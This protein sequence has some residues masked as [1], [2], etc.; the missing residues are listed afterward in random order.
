MGA[1]F[2]LS[3]APL[4]AQDS[5]QMY[6]IG[7][8]RT[9]VPPVIDGRL[10]EPVWQTAAVIDQFTQQEP[11]EGAPVSERTEVRILYD[12]NYLYIGLHAFDS[13]PEGIVATEMRRDSER[14][15]EEDN[16]QIIIDTFRDFRSAYMFVTNPLGAKLEQQ[17]FEEGE[18]GRRGSSS[19]INRD[20]DGVWHSSA[21]RVADG[22]VAEIAIP[23][24]TLRFPSAGTQDWGINFMRNIGRKNEQAFW[25]PIPKGHGITRVS[26]AGI[27]TD[28]TGLSRGMDLRIKP[29][30]VGGGRSVADGSTR[31]TMQRDVGVDLK[32]GIA[33]GFNLDLTLNTDFAQA[34][35]DDERVNLTRFAL[36]FPEKRD[37]FLENA[38]QFNVGSTASLF[39]L[40][41]L[42][43]SRNIG[44]TERGEHVPILGGARL[45]GKQ[46]RNNVAVMSVQTDDAFGMQGENFFVSRYSR[47][48][49]SRSKVGGIFIN[50]QAMGGGHF[51]RTY[52]GDMTLALTPA[53]N[54]NGF[55]A[56][57]SSPGESDGQL[58][59]HFRA[60]YLDRSWNVYAEYTDLQDNFNA[61]V[62][63]VPRVGIRTSKFHV[64]RNPRP[65]RFGIR[66]M[67]PMINVTN[68]TDQSGRV[69]T[70]QWHY[71]VG[72]RFE[73]GAYLNLW[74]NDYYEVLDRPF[75][76]RPDVIIAPGTYN[77][78]DFRASFSSSNARR[79]YYSLAYS[80]QTFFGGTRTD[81]DVRL[82]MRV[83]SRLAT[84]GQFSRNDVKL[85]VGEFTANIGSARVDYALS[86]TMTLRTLTQ[87]NSLTRQW[88]T[89]SRFHYI[90]RPGSDFYLVYNNVR[91]D[92]PGLVEF[93]DHHLILKF[94][95]LLSR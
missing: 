79:F 56:K 12:E 84:E 88:S 60:G 63:F 83:S 81:S 41:D 45:T 11:N 80:P 53:I 29:F 28:L 82:G 70:R 78:G 25:A 44:L 37:F 72:T 93:R 2:L 22:W 13:N 36:F 8:V 39:R 21:R 24:V 73:N 87:Y 32:Y 42:F 50:K 33:P 62:G 19:N 85:P 48:V 95:Y 1:A 31:N 38:G 14:M 54:V 47:D 17:V 86:P 89:S 61:E 76:L 51:N 57:T 90:Y 26:Q 7:A 55:L 92:I 64:E 52:A 18:G 6:M 49:L 15:M 67:E 46:G 94:T 71:M 66:V 30:A 75:R 58:G 43:F 65:G 77:Y 68:T 27:L 10:D 9:A 59:G 16:F 40:A 20:W 74:Y 69:V 4:S 34:E 5:R 23:V 35:I 3:A 91:R